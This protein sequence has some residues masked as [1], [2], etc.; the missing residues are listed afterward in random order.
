MDRRVIWLPSAVDDLDGIAANISPD[1][2]S[3]ASAVVQRVLSAAADL[4][5]F[6]DRGRALP[7][8]DD[9]SVREIYVHNWRL[10]YQVTSHQVI[11]LTVIHGA[12][13]LPASLR[14]RIP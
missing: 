9:N 12:R 6:S 7:E 13:V 5:Q 10:I 1:S 8:W 14:D 11:V 2:A 3:Y 4:R